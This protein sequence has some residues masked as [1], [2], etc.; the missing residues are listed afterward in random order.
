MRLNVVNV[1]R[2][3]GKIQVEPNQCY[4]W[5]KAAD[6]IFDEPGKNLIYNAKSVVIKIIKYA[7]SDE[8]R[9]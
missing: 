5:L 1:V 3:K 4:V 6:A 9:D 7:V 2:T 8:V